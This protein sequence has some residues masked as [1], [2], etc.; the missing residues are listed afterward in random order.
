MTLT[1]YKNNLRSIDR[2]F[3]S[4]NEI[5]FNTMLKELLQ[6][7]II[8]CTPYN[9]NTHI[10]INKFLRY[11]TDPSLQKREVAHIRRKFGKKPKLFKRKSQNLKKRYSERK[12]RFCYRTFGRH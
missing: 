12:I 4:K 11:F 9:G 6:C 7:K 1:R 5:H 8:G 2:C 3:L 10:L